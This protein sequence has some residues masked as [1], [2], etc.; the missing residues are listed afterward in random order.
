MP[1]N[2]NNNFVRVLIV[3]DEYMNAWSLAIAIKPHFE[4]RHAATVDEA[5]YWLRRE[6]FSFVMMDIR[7]GHDSQAGFRLLQDVK[8]QQPEAYVF[9]TTGMGSGK[10]ES[11]FLEAGFDAFY[12]KPIEEIE[13]LAEM[14]RLQNEKKAA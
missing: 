4:V 14:L 2:T 11:V 12:P 1:M 5:L 3:E 10:D 9:A 6:Q 13:V 8:I 7:L